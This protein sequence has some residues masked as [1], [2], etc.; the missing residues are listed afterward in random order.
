MESATFTCGNCGKDVPLSEAV[1]V[2]ISERVLSF[3]PFGP[4]PERVCRS[5]TGQVK[6][7]VLISITLV[8]GAAVFGV[9]WLLS[10]S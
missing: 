1:R 5:C 7:A 10:Q 4:F 2:S 3:V 8:S 6:A 9:Y